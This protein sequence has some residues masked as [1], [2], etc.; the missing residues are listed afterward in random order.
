MKPENPNATEFFGQQDSQDK[1]IMKEEFTGLGI[2]LGGAEKIGR[3]SSVLVCS[4]TSIEVERL[5]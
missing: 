2:S 4:N 5:P 3:N 1:A